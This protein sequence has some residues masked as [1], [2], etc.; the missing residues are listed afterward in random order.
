MA[1]TRS[2]N[3]YQPEEN[4]GASEQTSSTTS[5][6]G[7]RSGVHPRDE[8]SMSV[9]SSDIADLNKLTMSNF[10]RS[11]PAPAGSIGD[12]PGIKEEL[13]DG[14]RAERS[15]IIADTIASRN[16]MLQ[17]SEKD[18]RMETNIGKSQPMEPI[19]GKE[20]GQS[21]DCTPEE[22]TKKYGTSGQHIKTTSSA[23]M[24]EC[25]PSERIEKRVYYPK[26]AQE[27]MERGLSNVQRP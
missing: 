21:F 25:N 22:G 20:S 27:P 18:D 24:E 16:S 4:P 26:S 12:A 19:Y 13:Y 9:K 5:K 2:G 8:K 15:G 10:F 23:T 3:S 14:K 7:R 11:E 6:G 1:P 17:C